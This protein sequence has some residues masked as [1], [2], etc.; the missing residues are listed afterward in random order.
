MSGCGMCCTLPGELGSLWSSPST[1][2]CGKS[3]TH[4]AWASLPPGVI[5]GDDMLG[6]GSLP[7][8]GL[9]KV[10]FIIISNDEGQ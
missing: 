8:E 7:L 6:Y 1:G 10:E 4:Q 2:T 5:S 9:D 3:L